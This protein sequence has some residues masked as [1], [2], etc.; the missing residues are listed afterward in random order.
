MTIMSNPTAPISQ[1]HVARLVAEAVRT[2][3]TQRPHD[4]E[5]MAVALRDVYRVWAADWVTSEMG[6]GGG[7]GVFARDGAVYLSYQFPGRDWD[8]KFEWVNGRWIAT[9]HDEDD[10]GLADPDENRGELPL[11]DAFMA[12][13]QFDTPNAHRGV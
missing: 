4:A 7:T 10:G 1:E 9:T 2:T 6:G 13:L 5:A 12:G 11:A 3:S 8:V